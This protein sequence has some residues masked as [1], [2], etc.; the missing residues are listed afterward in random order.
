[1]N[2]FKRHD[3]NPDWIEIYNVGNQDVDLTGW[4]IYDNGGQAG[5][6]PKK[7]FPAGEI[8]PAN[9]FYVIITDDT[10]ASGFGLSSNGETVWLENPDGT[11][12]DELTFPALDVSQSYGRKPDGSDNFLYLPKLRVAART[13]M[14]LHY[15]NINNKLTHLNESLWLKT[16]KLE[17]SPSQG[18]NFAASDKISM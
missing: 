8:I 4:K 17:K 7:E 1:M 14:Q 9:G 5:T 10:T 16:S 3:T 12:A 13:T 2:I 11:V 6:K 15:Q 18:S